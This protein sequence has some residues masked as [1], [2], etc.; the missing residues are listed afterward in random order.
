MHVSIQSKSVVSCARVVSKVGW[1]T[2]AGVQSIRKRG[3]CRFFP[4]A[5]TEAR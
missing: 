1:Q 5:K 4:E 3:T 2:A